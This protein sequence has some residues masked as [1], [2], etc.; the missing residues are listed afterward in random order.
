MSV[1]H[2]AAGV[3]VINRVLRAGGR[4]SVFEPINRIYRDDV[5]TGGRDLA[6]TGGRDLS[7]VQ[8][9]HDRIVAFLQQGQDERNPMLD[10]DERDLVRWCV[11]AGFTSV[12]LTYEVSYFHGAPRASAAQISAALRQRPNPLQLSYEEGARA[13]LG[14]GAD[15]FLARYVDL[16]RAQPGR[17]VN[18]AAYV[19]AV[20]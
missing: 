1:P 17:N 16:L 13:V 19:T 6:W 12:R 9:E 10:F 3:R 20:K 4:L 5:W 7:A 11:D 2:H 14:D 18:A 8:P 15:V